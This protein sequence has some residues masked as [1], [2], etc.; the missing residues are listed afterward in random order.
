MSAGKNKMNKR[1]N[2]LLEERKKL[3]H[4]AG[5]KLLSIKKAK[6]KIPK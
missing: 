2:E 3:V 1:I 4:E 6:I 5:L